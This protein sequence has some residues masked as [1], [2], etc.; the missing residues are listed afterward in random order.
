M[1]AHELF[2][3]GPT[4]FEITPSDWPGL[5]VYIKSANG[6][7]ATGRVPWT[8]CSPRYVIQQYCRVPTDR[9]THVHLP[10]IYICA[11]FFFSFSLHFTSSHYYYCRSTSFL[12]PSYVSHVPLW[13]SDAHSRPKDDTAVVQYT[14]T[15]TYTGPPRK[16]VRW[17]RP[18]AFCDS[19]NG[20]TRRFFFSF[21]S[22]Q[23]RPSVFLMAAVRFT[24]A[25]T[26]T[27]T[28][29]NPTVADTPGPREK[30][31]PS[32]SDVATAVSLSV[33]VFCAS[34]LALF[35]RSRRFAFADVV[36]RFDSSFIRLRVTTTA[37]IAVHLYILSIVVVWRLWLNDHSTFPYYDF[38]FSC[39]VR[40]KLIREIHYFV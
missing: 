18:R 10:G 34:R 33:T 23:R 5:A 11:I 4:D 40:V 14:H 12:F 27:T 36:S 13:P 16:N 20:E 35:Q 31:P 8:P 32:F 6:S 37:I 29:D 30:A 2:A 15:G 19:A 3:R 9:Y 38:L 25:T 17:R 26:T 28:T 1:L 22:H 21:Y 24:P 7:R 39:G